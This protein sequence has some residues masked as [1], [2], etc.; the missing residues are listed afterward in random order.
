MTC[1]TE[2]GFTKMNYIKIKLQYIIN[3]YLACTFVVVVRGHSN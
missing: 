3:Y 1:I 2:V